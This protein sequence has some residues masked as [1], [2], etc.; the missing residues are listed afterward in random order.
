[1]GVAIAVALDYLLQVVGSATMPNILCGPLHAYVLVVRFLLFVKCG[2]L[3]GPLQSSAN[4]LYM[5]KSVF[6]IFHTVAMLELQ[7]SVRSSAAAVPARWAEEK[8]TRPYTVA[9]ES[10]EFGGWL[11][12]VL[13][14]VVLIETVDQRIAYG[15]HDE[16]RH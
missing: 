3:L 15:G 5:M 1:M 6:Q 2:P 10:G 13:K 4:F 9:V 12:R 16:P 8:L 14:W 7:A 11:L